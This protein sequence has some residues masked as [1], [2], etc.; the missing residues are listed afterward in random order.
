MDRMLPF[1]PRRVACPSAVPRRPPARLRATLLALS[2][3]GAP[4][5]ARADSVVVFNE[6]MYHPPTNEAAM[7]WVELYNQM[8]VDVD[9]SGW[10]L[11]GGISYDFAEGTVLPGGGYLIVASAPATFM[12]VTGLTNVLGP[13]TGRLAN[14]G[15]QLDL[16]NR[17]QR[18]MD[19]LSY[20]VDGDW[21][22]GPD[23]G[24]VS[25]AKRDPDTASAPAGNWTVSPLMGGTPGRRNFA[26]DPVEVTNTTPLLINGDWRFNASGAELGAVWR[27]PAFD[28]STWPAGLALF[29][30]GGVTAQAGDPQPLPGVFSS[31]VGED[32]A[33]L[34]PGL[35]DPHY[36]LMESP[37][38]TPPPPAI[39]A[40]VILNHPAWHAN[41]ALSRWIGP[42]NPGETSVPPGDYTFRASFSLTG[43]DPASAS[44][45]LRVAVDNRLNTV[46]LN[47]VDTGISHAGYAALSGNFFITNGFVA[48]TN[49]LD[50]L[51]VND[52]SSPN[53]AGLRVRLSGTARPLLAS[54]TQLPPGRTN[55]YFRTQFTLP[56]APAQTSARLQAVIA[57]GAVFYLNG[58]EVLR[59]NLPPGP[60]NAGTL[61]VSN[62][63]NPS[64]LGPFALPGA[65][66][67][68]GTNVL[69]VELHAASGAGLTNMLFGAT[70]ELTTTNVLIP[71]PMALAFNEVA[72]GTN[73]DFGLELMNHGTTPLDLGGCVITRRGTGPEQRFT[74]APQTLAA[75]AIQHLSAATLGFGLLPG[76]R[77]FLHPPDQGSVLDAV[78]VKDRLRGRSPDGSGQWWFPATPTPG[79]SNAFTFQRDVVIN[80]IMY[81]APLLPPAPGIIGTEELLSI[82]NVWRAHSLGMDLGS[83]WRAPGYDDSAWPE[84]RALF[85]HTASVLPA[86]K[87]TQLPLVNAAGERIITWYFR[88]PFLYTGGTNAAQ[89]MFS[90]IVDDGAVY[91]LNGVECFRQN[92]PAGEIRYTNFASG[93][94]ATPTYSGP[95][96][97]AVTNLLNGTNLLAVEVHQFTTN[98][99]AADMAFGVEVR[100]VGQVTPALPARESPEAW[101]ELYNRGTNTVDLTGWRVDGGIDYRFPAG[102]TLP[103]DGYLVVARDVEF[104]QALHPGLDVV[105]P[106][107]NQLS[108]SGELLLLKDAANNLADEVHYHDSGRWPEY[109]D[110][111]G[112][113][114]ELR[115]PWADRTKAEAWAASD[116]TARAGWSNFTYRAVA[117]NVLG[118]TLWKEFVIG[119]LEG[120]EC[121]IDDLRVVESPDTAPVE[122][123]QNGSFEDG[124][125]AWRALGNHRGSRVEPEPGNPANQVLR[126]IATGPTDHLHNHLE[127][128][129]AGGR[130][131]TD[132]RT[133]EIS[134]RAKW[135]A[136]NHRL[137]TRLYFNRVART[138]ALPL[139]AKR[140][141][142]G[143][144]NSTFATNLGPTFTSFQHGPIVPQP[145]EP[146][147]V[148]ASVADPQGVTTVTLHWS[149]NSGPWQSATMSPD[150]AT[151]APGYVNYA[152]A[153]PGL[154]AGTLV[155]FYVE[156]ADGLGAN[157]TFPARGRDS[158]ALFKVSEDKSLMTQLH[159]L[160]LLMLPADVQWLHSETNV[161]SNEQLGLTLVHDER[162]VFYDVG[163]HL[164]GSERGRSVP[165][166]V[167]YSVRFS[168][169]QL[170]RGT[171]PKLTIDRSGGYSGRGGIHDEILLWHAANHAG[172]LLGLECDL[173]QVFAPRS[174]EDGTGLLR[175]AAFDG[176]YFDGQFP[177]GGDGSRYQL[178]LI[179]SPTTS[180]G[181]DPQAPKLPQPDEV[182]NGDLQNWGSDPENYRWILLQENQAARDDYSQAIA[183]SRAF[184]L[185]GAALDAQTR[186][187]L[188]VDEW[189]R[190]LAFAAFIGAG[191]FFSFGLNHNWKLYFRPDDGRALGL[192]WDMDFAFVLPIESSFPGTS[193][194]G[195]ERL[196][197]LPDNHRRYYHHLLDLMTTTIN[198]GHLGPWNTRYAGSLGQNWQGTVT[199]LQQRADYIRGFLPLTTPFAITNHGGQNFGTTN[200]TVALGGTAP[201][202]VKT[203]EV[204]GVSY[205]LTWTTL[206]N[207]TLTVPLPNVVNILAFQGVDTY[208]A[209]LSNAVASITVTNRGLLAPGPVVVNEWMADNAGP[210]GFADPLDE[211]F[212]DWIELFNPNDVP[213]N[214]SGYTL[215]DNLSQPAKWRIPTNTVIAPRGFLLV[216][217]DGEVAQNGLGDTGDLHANFSLSKGGEALGLYA[218]DGTPQ[219]R[220]TFGAQFENVS[221]GLFPDGDTN[222]LYLMT[223]WSPRA[224]NRLGAPPPPALGGLAM[225]ADGTVSFAAN[226][227]PGRTYR[228]EF[229]DSLTAPAW[230]PLGDNFTATEP[231][232]SIVDQP[233]PRPQRYYRLVLLQ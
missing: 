30:A 149:V 120:G 209:R 153:L 136:G 74:L 201:L 119:L 66:L 212:Q 216:W 211:L 7:E 60:V 52:G 2:L 181:G 20:G 145:G 44:L 233:G 85:Y 104:M 93:G 55:Y 150:G 143:A 61:A 11:S 121:L 16:R 221:Q 196:V 84:G 62:V 101:I 175:L 185:S 139:P 45:M 12:G 97:V 186:Q 223:H 214:L 59:W 1:T 226:V 152:A 220:L 94:V 137:N 191:D 176:D 199:Y 168:P 227:V 148:G 202:T 213:V 204:N 105:G 29:Q 108:R 41:D 178:E 14:E 112:S 53:P 170:F 144:R 230:T 231:I 222:S 64:V 147:T 135:L 113:S 10:S 22:V 107:D 174:S 133:Y 57:D 18:L 98:P 110:G 189:L 63:P 56:G 65:P 132:G 69:A 141:T 140:G 102:T 23:D 134:F 232:L 13:F 58:M 51:T 90:P 200:S 194:P 73:S 126:L 167:G 87:L 218:P 154:P 146:V 9:L 5:I 203:I 32:G 151:T 70:L 229:K 190:T 128:T 127:T 91:Y 19:R 67:V 82:T 173:V 206:T 138:T 27:E 184:S 109:A 159:R 182:I 125:T 192:L 99:I 72:S 4:V 165:S 68:A 207:W 187:L 43:F 81:H 33:V 123:L 46:L 130:A 171:Q 103:P 50:F 169:D 179:Y 188:D 8:A 42:V 24:G 115:D 155:Q 122:L 92:L 86:P 228:V 49:T 225:A 6:I 197:R 118:P 39:P 35:P 180:V 83:A 28:D 25:L 36:R 164:Q 37:Y 172:G 15:E 163:V 54:H 158:R 79:G 95:L 124:L 208:G 215:T 77:L 183:V 114:L 198:A 21:P 96:T 157:A 71:P 195:T 219:H 89:L 156:A 47:G 31:G 162:E 131:V 161:M 129:L 80:E 17:S 26:S 166:R 217:A 224:S 48:G 78:V 34:P 76:D 100:L 111:G 3:L 177:N 38:S 160:S 117:Q 106:F 88:T 210:A 116:E 40:T 205:A 75:G 142:P 193:S